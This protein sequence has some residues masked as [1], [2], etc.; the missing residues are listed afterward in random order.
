MAALHAPAHA[1]VQEEKGISYQIIIRHSRDIATIAVVDILLANPGAHEGQRHVAPLPVHAHISASR[2]KTGYRIASAI[3]RRCACVRNHV[4]AEGD[5]AVSGDRRIPRQRQRCQWPPLSVQLQSDVPGFV[6]VARARY[7]VLIQS[8][9]WNDFIPE[10][11]PERASNQ[12][13]RFSVQSE[14]GFEVHKVLCR[15]QWTIR[16]RRTAAAHFKAGRKAVAGLFAII[17]RFHARLPAGQRYRGKG[18]DGLLWTPR[19]PEPRVEKDIGFG[20]RGPEECLVMDT[21]LPPCG[22]DFALHRPSIVPR[23]HMGSIHG[24]DGLFSP[25]RIDPRIRL[26]AHDIL[27][28]AVRFLDP[29]PSQAAV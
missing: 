16:V 21:I 25:E 2:R 13:P 28:Q 3:Q 17:K 14:S 10:F 26:R 22:L 15:N 8:S 4:L 12:S 1:S 23:S 29:S 11:H 6:S 9:A 27:R 19:N 18:A 7:A 5:K 20:E 24:G